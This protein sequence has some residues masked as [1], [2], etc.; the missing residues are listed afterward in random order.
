VEAPIDSDNHG[1]FFLNSQ[2]RSRD[3]PDGATHTIFLGEK[4]VDADDLGWM[5]GTRATLRNTG[6]PINGAS[7]VAMGAGARPDLPLPG[8]AGMAASPG[9]KPGQNETARQAGAAEAE[10][11]GLFVGGFSSS[12]PGGANFL[13]GD[14]SGR[15]LSE[16]IDIPTYQQ[17]GHRADGKLRNASF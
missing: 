12:H 11:A 14:G 17:L 2:V 9:D 16:T 4:L 8:A 5:S 10:A 3:I 13:L 15:F 6:T 1:V 7:P